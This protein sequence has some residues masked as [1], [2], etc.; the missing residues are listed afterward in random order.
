MRSKLWVL[1]TTL[2]ISALLLAACPAPGADAPSGDSAGSTSTETTGAV[3]ETQSSGAADGEPVTI[4]IWHGWAGDYFT[5]IEQVFKDYTAEHPN[6]TIELSRPEDLNQSAKVAIPAGEGPDIFAWVNDQIGD[7][8]L[9]GNIV[10]LNDLGIDEEF[11]NSTYEPAAVNGVIW[12]GQIWGLPE[13][14]EGIALI[15]NKALVT[16]EYLPTDPNDFDDLLAKATA[17]KEATGLPLICNQGFP[18]GDAYHVAPVYFG[19]GVPSYVDDEGKVNIDSP[20]A[21]AAGQWLQAISK[22]VD[23][24][25]SGDICNAAF[26]EGKVGMW[27]TGPWSIAGVETAGIDYGIQPMGRPFVGIKTLMVT[28]NAVDRGTTEIAV[29]IMRYFTSADVQKALAVANKT[30]PAATAA[31]T[32]P[33]VQALPALAGF[34]E[35]LNLGQ[36]MANTPFASAQW[37]PVGDATAAIWS[38]AQTPEEAVAAAQTAIEAAIQQMQ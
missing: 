36:P 18:G 38:G 21:V 1:I 33:E 2:L 31:V 20:E 37:Q 4:T 13:T 19:F 12:Q 22:V 10:P 8:A 24:E 11:L 5:A 16:E 23:T 32:D 27:W 26:A 14:Q 15:Y 6:V 7:Q 29:D 3:T 28:A 30:I 35:A 17:F 25:Q 34:G 9:S